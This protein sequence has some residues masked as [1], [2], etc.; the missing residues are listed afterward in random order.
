MLIKNAGIGPGD[1]IGIYLH[2][3]ACKPAFMR[4]T[5]QKTSKEDELLTPKLDS[6]VSG[7]AKD[8]P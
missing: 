7:D 2:L 1:I 3:Y 6:M 4:K 8:K 5:R